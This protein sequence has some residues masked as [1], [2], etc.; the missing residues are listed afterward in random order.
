M[1]DIW[2]HIHFLMPLQDA[3]CAACVSHAFLRSWRCRPA[4][5]FSS[6]TLGLNV[7]SR[8]KGDIASD[9]NSKVDH[10]LEKRLGIGL[11]ILEI[12]YCGYNADTCCY[13]SRWLA[14]TITPELEE[15]S[16]WLP[17]VKAKYIFPLSLLSN[18][19]GKSIRHLRLT[20]C[21]ISG[22]GLDCLK[23]L[24]SLYLHKVRITGDDLGSLFFSSIA[25]ERLELY[26]CQKIICLKIPSVLQRLSFVSVFGCVRLKVIENKAPNI[27]SFDFSFSGRKVE[28]SLGEPLQV[29]FVRLNMDNCISYACANL[30]SLVPN[31]ET[32]ILGT[33][34]EVCIENLDD[35]VLVM[36]L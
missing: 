24:R 30:P 10:I 11:K 32:L 21:A 20:G 35:Y 22:S 13:L 31:L 9:F 17:P 26:S 1:Q 34:Y 14:I 36:C 15:L 27:S 6:A 7:N 3:A 2:R 29:K 12:E 16:L 4:M 5:S 8:R 23:N 28:L 33:S 25:L 19:S 18:G